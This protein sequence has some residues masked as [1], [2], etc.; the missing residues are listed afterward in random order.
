MNRQSPIKELLPPIIVSIIMVGL[1]ISLLHNIGKRNASVIADIEGGRAVV[2]SPDCDTSLLSG[3]I[4]DDGYAETKED[5]DFIASVLVERQR[6]NGQLPSLY[7]V[8]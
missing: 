4:Y 6:K 3:I 8:Q 2:L 5:A 7:I 1:F